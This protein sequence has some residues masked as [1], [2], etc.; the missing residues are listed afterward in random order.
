MFQKTQLLFFSK[1]TISK[2]DPVTLKTNNSNRH[3]INGRFKGYCFG[4][5]PWKTDKEAIYT[6]AMPLL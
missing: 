6:T 5:N 4:Q 1:L 2:P 3:P